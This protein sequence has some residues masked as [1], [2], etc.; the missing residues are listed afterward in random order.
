MRLL[1]IGV[2]GA[3]LTLGLLLPPCAAMLEVQQHLLLDHTSCLH[4]DALQVWQQGGQWRVFENIAQV[5]SSS[6]STPTI[7]TAAAK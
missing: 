1:Q 7:T 6:S 3:G 5:T 2:H 4:H